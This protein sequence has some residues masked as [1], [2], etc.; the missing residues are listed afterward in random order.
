[1]STKRWIFCLCLTSLLLTG[2]GRLWGQNL[3]VT[4]GGSGEVNFSIT[5]IPD[6]DPNR[7]NS[8]AHYKVF[9]NFGDGHYAL[10][11]VIY[12]HDGSWLGS[13]DTT[14]TY[15]DDPVPQ[16]SFSFRA[17][18]TPTYSP[19][20]KDILYV[21][22][23][24][25]LTPNQ[26]FIHPNLDL[27]SQVIH[28]D[29][30]RDPKAGNMMSMLLTY[31]TADDC[32]IANDGGQLT[33]EYGAGI[34]LA[35]DPANGIPE[36]VERFHEESITTNIPGK[37]VLEILPNTSDIH[38]QRNLILNFRTPETHP[39][40][41]TYLNVF[42]ERDSAGLGGICGD[43]LE[44]TVNIR[45]K[46]KPYD[47]NFKLVDIDTISLDH[48]QLLTYSIQIQNI[49]KGE[50]DSITV[51]DHLDPRLDIATLV[52]KHVSL[53]Y[54]EADQT[55]L[56]LGNGRSTANSGLRSQLDHFEFDYDYD[57]SNNT[58][59]WV[60]HNDA[61]I[62]G[63]KQRGYISDFQEDE[64]IAR[65][66]YEI[67]T[68]PLKERNLKIENIAEVYFDSLDVVETTPALTV[69]FCCQERTDE[70]SVAFDLLSYAEV[71]TDSTV[72]IDSVKVISATTD[73]L[74]DFQRPQIQW[75][76]TNGLVSYVARP[77]FQGTD[78]VILSLCYRDNLSGEQL[79]DTVK[80][81]ICVD[82]GPNRYPCG[83]EAVSEP[84]EDPHVLPLPWIPS[85]YPLICCLLVLMIFVC[86][87]VWRK[88]TSVPLVKKPTS[89]KSGR[90]SVSDF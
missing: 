48:A 82:L 51:I 53:G 85:G 5:N 75:L 39:G 17:E 9:W 80:V 70:D 72:R 71:A 33:I 84:S 41:N 14:Y 69:K 46:R 55:D 8:L 22:Q 21:S 13:I 56:R 86:W 40:G 35:D 31:L 45:S 29:Q 64:T 30:S 89:G 42:L 11:S 78:V 50:T 47:P 24:L 26:P 74:P 12:Q 36:M 81:G 54:Q 63:T 90:A 73:S 34:E 28:I 23:P 83:G 2:V 68:R 6:P 19:P 59:T 44:K 38:V 4:Y 88:K 27:E 57:L 65:I 67:K 7:T 25:T 43:T 60:L 49:G 16:N 77:S 3:T 18:L 62:K 32:G 76:G 1:M 52:V 37:L 66:E 87:L 20:D 58:I 61:R 79:C 10:D 15:T